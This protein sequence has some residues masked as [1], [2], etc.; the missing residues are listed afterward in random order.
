[1]ISIVSLYYKFKSHHNLQGK[2]YQ[3]LQLSK[4]TIQWYQK[5]AFITEK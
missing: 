4:M 3:S 1:M 2:V 5:D